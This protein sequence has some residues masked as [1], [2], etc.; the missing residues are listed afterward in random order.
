MKTVA[1]TG[2]ALL[3]SAAVAAQLLTARTTS[4]TVNQIRLDRPVGDGGGTAAPAPAP[5]PSGVIQDLSVDDTLRIMRGVKFTSIG[6]E[7]GKA[8]RF[9]KA[10]IDDQPFYIWHNNCTDN[11]CRALHFAAYLG[12]QDSVSDAFIHDYNRN[13]MFTKMAKDSKGELQVTMG[14]SLARGVTEEHVRFMGEAWI[15][16]FKEAIAYKPEGN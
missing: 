13:T 10:S 14:V 12:Q 9:I 5:R 4:D 1:L 8:S 16:Y 7:Q 3:A 2:I 15:I 6:I 11:R